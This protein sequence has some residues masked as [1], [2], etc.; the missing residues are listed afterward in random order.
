[1]PLILPNCPCN[2]RIESVRKETTKMEKEKMRLIKEGISEIIKSISGTFISQRESL[3][4]GWFNNRMTVLLMAIQSV[5]P[6]LSPNVT[7][8]VHFFLE[9]IEHHL[10]GFDPSDAT[11]EALSFLKKYFQQDFESRR[12]DSV[13]AVRRVKRVYEA[14]GVPFDSY[15]ES[16]CKADLKRKKKTGALAPC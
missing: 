15:P 5:R 6:A 3:F 1:M 9:D 2:F 11:L 10:V 13:E 12:R 8:R 7:L 14:V 4:I 16:Q